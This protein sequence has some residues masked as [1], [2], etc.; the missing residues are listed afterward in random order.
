MKKQTFILIVI[1]YGLFLAALLLLFPEY[2]VQSFDGD[3]TNVD[4]TSTMRFFGVLHFAYN[5]LALSIRKSTDKKVVGTYLLAVAISF[6]GSLAVGAYYVLSGQV[7]FQSNNWLDLI[8]WTVLGGGALY[9]Y[10]D[11]KE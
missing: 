8:G 4:E 6:F 5:F 10:F 2:A 11:G 3:P 7:N 1:I 9:Y